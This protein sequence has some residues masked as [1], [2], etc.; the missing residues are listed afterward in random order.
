MSTIDLPNMNDTAE[1]AGL[2]Q[3]IRREVS[4]VT[5]EKPRVVPWLGHKI[6]QA[7]QAACAAVSSDES[8][9]R[10]V[11]AEVEFRLKRER[12]LFI[13]V[14]QLQDLVEETLIELGHAK[15][16]LAYAKYRTRRAA[17]REAAQEEEPVVEEQLEL[18]SRDLLTDI[19]ARVSFASIGLQL[20]LSESELIDRL[21]R[22]ASMA[23]S[24]EEQ[25]DTII[26]NA[27]SLLDLD[28]DARFFAGRILLTYIYEETLP[29]K[30]S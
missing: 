20:A 17:L 5:S 14:E 1:S 11:R 25:R 3:V 19:R 2:P 4:H 27:K 18:A 29:W 8:V 9:G 26:L 16:A 15:V 6:E 13:H 24:P 30:I 7:V 21:L 23:L 12:S 28:A 22:S 10:Q